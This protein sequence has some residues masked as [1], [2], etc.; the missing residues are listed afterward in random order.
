[1]QKLKIQHVSKLTYIKL[2]GVG[3]VGCGAI[4]VE[5][6]DLL[7]LILGLAVAFR[8]DAGRRIP[9]EVHVGIFPVVHGEC[10]LRQ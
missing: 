2:D 9:V 4:E 5:I 6:A 7:P 1:M 10:N 3:R 8:W